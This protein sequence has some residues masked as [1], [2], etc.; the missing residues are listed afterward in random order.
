[1]NIK[2]S[3]KEYRYINNRIDQPI[4]TIIPG[5]LKSPDI[6]DRPRKINIT[7]LDTNMVGRMRETRSYDQALRQ[8]IHTLRG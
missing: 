8:M 4:D 3:L 6:K 2:I 7:N 1:M 5:W